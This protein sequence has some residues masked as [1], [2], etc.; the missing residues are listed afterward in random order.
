MLKKLSKIFAVAAL[1]FLGSPAA[2]Q[3]QAEA[4]D[5]K[6]AHLVIGNADTISAK[7]MEELRADFGRTQ[8]GRDLLAFADSNGVSMVSE[9]ELHADGRL[10]VFHFAGHISIQSGMT[11]AEQ[12]VVL[13]HEIW[14][15][16]QELQLNKGSIDYQTSLMPLQ[17][18]DARQYLEADAR[19]FSAYFMA[20]RRV[21][22]GIESGELTTGY[23]TFERGIA[24]QLENEMRGDG[25]SP[26]EYRLMALI[27]SFAH[28]GNY[29]SMHERIA[30]AEN[31]WFDQ[32]LRDIRSHLDQGGFDEAKKIIDKT[33]EKLAT[34]P[35]DSLFEATLRRY[36]AT[37][38]DLS[39]PTALSDTSE[40]T[41]NDLTRVFPFFADP[42][43]QSVSDMTRH[44]T[45]MDYR[46]SQ[47]EEMKEEFA[48][49]KG[50][51]QRE[52]WAAFLDSLKLLPQQSLK[53]P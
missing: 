10:G 47:F 33:N 14:H 20:D 9:P 27:P 38:L 25:L 26:A 34:A 40:I 51:H 22:L 24:D 4:R 36:G 12:I 15:A 30:I 8:L 37:S 39:A 19:A 7:E 18:W 29:K 16:Y 46:D 43:S 23:I 2:A 11:R 41:R 1:G 13:A 53:G 49:L 5:H 52:S 17:R 44:R 3:N 6:C 31:D 50:R 28:I 35:G 21:K 32:N 45:E 48:F 42:R